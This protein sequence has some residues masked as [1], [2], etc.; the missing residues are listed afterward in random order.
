MRYTVF[1]G[2]S[3]T[4]G[5]GLLNQSLDSDLWVNILHSTVDRLKT[6]QL[7]NVGKSGGTNRDIFLNAVDAVSTVDCEYL[8]VSWTELFRMHLDPGTETYSTNLYFGP[9]CQIDDINL[10]NGIMYSAKYIENIKN[11]LFDLYSPHYLMV[12]IVNYTN[13]LKKLCDK[14]G[15]TVFFLNALVTEWDLNYF[16][17]ITT[18]DRTPGMTT[19]FTQQMLNAATRDDDEYFTIYDRIHQEYS[20][21]KQFN[22]L[23]ID[24]CYRNDFFLDRGLDN[25]HPGIKSNRAFANFLIQKL[26]AFL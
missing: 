21:I 19:K 25:L 17:Q 15:I 20:G 13:I 11:R 26:Q 14:L 18:P 8:F 16:D 22:W 6:T 23:N 12:E 7:M 3:Y 1:S 9:K 5:V 4:V 2:C 24:Q 10:N